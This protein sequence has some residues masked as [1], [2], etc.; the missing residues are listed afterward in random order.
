MVISKKTLIMVMLNVFVILIS[1]G[2]DFNHSLIRKL[3]LNK[4]K[5]LVINDPILVKIRDDL[6][7]TPLHIAV[8]A[9]RLPLV[10]FFIQSGS[11]VNAT[12]SLKAFSPLHYACLHSYTKTARFLLARG[13]FVNFPDIDG[14][15]PL[16]YAA[17][18]G[19]PDLVE[20]LLLHGARNDVLN[21]FSQSPLSNCLLLGANNKLFPYARRPYLSFLKTVELLHSPAWLVNYAD[22]NG[23]TPIQN[24][25]SF[26]LPRE[27]IQKF[28]DAI[29]YNGIK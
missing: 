26:S 25:K 12:D 24:L 27:V 14:N 10:N 11:N 19:N 3:S 22:C 9:G 13:A 21:N 29:F 7:R 6:G 1:F 2:A 20:L 8:E 4:I 16:H 5:K 18:N 28:Y 17:G 15:T 23:H